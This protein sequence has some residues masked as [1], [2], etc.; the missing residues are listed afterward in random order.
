MILVGNATAVYGSAYSAG[1]GPQLGICIIDTGYSSDIQF[2]PIENCTS[3]PD[4][5]RLCSH[6]RDAGVR[7][8]PGLCK[9]Q[10]NLFCRVDYLC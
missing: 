9:L 8:Q 4:L 1:T 3:N 5:Q 2:I 7:C 10:S 6:D